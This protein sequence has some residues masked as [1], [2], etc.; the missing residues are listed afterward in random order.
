M[1]TRA[2]PGTRC[3]PGSPCGASTTR[4]A[5]ASP[6]P[7]PM[8]RSSI[9]PAC[10][11]A[12]SDIII[13]SPRHIS[14]ATLRSQLVA[15]PPPRQQRRAGVWRCPAGLAMQALRRFLWL[16]ATLTGR[17]DQPPF[18][19]S[20]GLGALDRVLRPGERTADGFLDQL[21]SAVI[22]GGDGLHLH[23]PF[24]EFSRRHRPRRV[25]QHVVD[26][27]KAFAGAKPAA[28]RPRLV[29]RSPHD[30]RS[31]ARA[32]AARR[33][34]RPRCVWRDGRSCG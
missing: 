21:A 32:E 29:V 1:P 3:T 16:L 28:A 23:D 12:F 27:A 18:N 2:R 14:L 6:A 17:L 20:R 13:I 5:I 9:S 33:A 24:G 25:T 7:A 19:D 15:R 30:R 10:A 4:T 26:Q 34:A 8:A 11:A 31:A 22:G